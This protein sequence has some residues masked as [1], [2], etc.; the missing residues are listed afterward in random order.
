[1]NDDTRLPAETSPSQA[2]F[3]PAT[4]STKQSAFRPSTLLQKSRFVRQ[5]LSRIILI[6]RKGLLLD[7]TD[8]YTHAIAISMGVVGMQALAASL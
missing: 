4:Q 2:G 7:V 6:P 5:L 8:P 1:M 3:E